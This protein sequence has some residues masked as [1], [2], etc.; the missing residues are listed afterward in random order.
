MPWV[1]GPGPRCCCGR[2][3]AVVVDEGNL[4]WGKGA[5]SLLCLVHNNQFNP[6]LFPLPKEC[7]PDWGPEISRERLDEIVLAG[8]KELKDGEETGN[9][10]GGDGTT[11]L[12]DVSDYLQ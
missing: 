5:A 2:R 1:S 10:L 4:G 6:V 11:G 12:P 8:Q 9:G 7:P 3:T